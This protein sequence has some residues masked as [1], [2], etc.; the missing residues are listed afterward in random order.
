M[1]MLMLFMLML[2]MLMLLLFIG[3]T[4]SPREQCRRESIVLER[5]SDASLKMAYIRTLLAGLVLGVAVL[6]A[7]DDWKCAR[8]WPDGCFSSGFE[9]LSHALS[10][11]PSLYVFR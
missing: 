6:G 5:S 1:L 10:F 2:F 11:R 3:T 7:E 8:K 4:N 9:H